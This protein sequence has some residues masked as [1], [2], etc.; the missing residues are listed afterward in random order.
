MAEPVAPDAVGFVVI[1]AATVLASDIA[2]PTWS[3]TIDVWGFAAV[4]SRAKFADLGTAPITSLGFRAQWSDLAAPADDDWVDV[5]W[6]DV[7]AGVATESV[8]NP[9]LDVSGATAPTST[10]YYLPAMGRT[11]RVGWYADAGDPAGS[12]FTGYAI[13]S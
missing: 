8:Y 9:I 5:Y 6:E 1:A 3:D 12:S 11:M 4:F 13:R 10:G 2:A 7:T